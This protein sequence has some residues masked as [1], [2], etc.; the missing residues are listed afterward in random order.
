VASRRTP[1][2]RSSAPTVHYGIAVFGP[3][4]TL[5]R[6]QL[7]PGPWVCRVLQARIYLWATDRLQRSITVLYLIRRFQPPSVQITARPPLAKVLCCIDTELQGPVF[8]NPIGISGAPRLVLFIYLVYACRNPCRLRAWT[9]T[10]T[11]SAPVDLT[12]HCVIPIHS[13][14]RHHTYIKAIPPRPIA[15]YRRLR[16]LGAL[17]S[18]VPV[19]SRR[20]PMRR[21][22]APTVH[23]CCLR[24]STYFKA[25]LF[26]EM[27]A[28]AMGVFSEHVY[29]S[30]QPTVCNGALLY[31]N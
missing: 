5:R 2:R 12:T 7:W 15:I 4:P 21:S 27:T 19:A 18:P 14:G 20:T 30:A 1:M 3:Q 11:F 23:Y 31:C 29:I 10:C 16:W 26:R 22:S 8:S 28:V 6:G 13:A 9:P 24:A 17:P 25:D